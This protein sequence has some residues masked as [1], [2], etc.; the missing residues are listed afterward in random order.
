MNKAK[1]TT[2]EA[3]RDDQIMEDISMTP[4]E[5]LDLAFR[6]SDFAVNIQKKQEPAKEKSPGI[7]WI[8]LRKFSSDR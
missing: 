2:P 1:V 7:Q 8:E 4:L 3:M 6:L 5:R